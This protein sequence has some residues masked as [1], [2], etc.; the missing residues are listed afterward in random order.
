VGLIGLVMVHVYFA[1]RPEK[2]V[3]TESMIGGSMDRDFY[4]E[5][6]DQERWKVPVGK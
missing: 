3:I 4:L 5:H 6:Y 1:L 2:F